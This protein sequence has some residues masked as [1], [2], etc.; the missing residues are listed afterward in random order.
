MRILHLIDHGV[1]RSSGRAEAGGD[2]AMLACRSLIDHA[3]AHEH[4][5]CLIGP[6]SVRATA[7]AH[8]L[9]DELHL[10][11]PMGRPILARWALR[12]LVADR[13]RPDLVQSW[14]PDALGLQQAAM[15]RVPSAAVFFVHPDRTGNDAA[16]SFRPSGLGARW[17]A[18]ALER[19]S[20]VVLS[21]TSK[22]AWKDSFAAIRSAR[23]AP[24]PAAP[25][26]AADSDGCGAKI[27]F[28]RDHGIADGD[29]VL[30]L[31]GQTSSQADAMRFMF[32]LDVLHV[33]CPGIVGLVSSGA[34]Q[35]SRGL[36]F[37]ARRRNSW[38]VFVSD[39][40]LPDLL[41]AADL[42]VSCGDR[43]SAMS[44][45]AA[46]C[47]SAAVQIGAA[48]R[49]GVPVVAPR[50]VASPAL[51]DHDAQEACIAF[52]AALPELARKLLP[53][54]SDRKLLGRVATSVV[55]TAQAHDGQGFAAAVQ[56]VWHEVQTIGGDPSDF[57]VTLEA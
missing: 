49:M 8:G 46:P 31:L 21:E 13:G 45:A 55:R 3:P 4:Q 12:R 33:S 18:R 50:E 19:T 2:A 57:A 15:P 48:H 11:A 1:N 44:G 42:A 10:P 6:T 53:L 9:S 28:R 5:V 29:L 36:C 27:G 17:L 52:N 23:V 35:I 47:A 37:Q 20:L 25:I 34:D 40:P 22:G 26:P 51:Y 39:R 30:L 14:S 56:D 41:S 7:R 43:F 54:H 16:L 32:L 38:R 24:L